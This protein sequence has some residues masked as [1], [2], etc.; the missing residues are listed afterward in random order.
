MKDALAIEWANAKT[1]RQEA[2][3]YYLRLLLN[4]NA[5][6]RVYQCGEKFSIDVPRS[7]LDRC[8]E[9]LEYRSLDQECVSKRRVREYPRLV[10]ALVGTLLGGV[11]GAVI[12]TLMRFPSTSLLAPLLALAGCF[13]G[14]A[15]K[16]RS[17]IAGTWKP[18]EQSRMRPDR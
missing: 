3:R 18:G 17:S 1:C 6:Y 12:T 7:D 9:L 10:R 14:L 2:A 5:A 11:C 15:F 8:N 4:A 16:A 13:V